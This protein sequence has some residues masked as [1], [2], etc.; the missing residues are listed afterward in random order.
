MIDDE[1]KHTARD[2]HHHGQC[3]PDVSPHGPHPVA[4]VSRMI[5]T[6]TKLSTVLHG[7]TRD[8]DGM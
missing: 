1:Y 3:A 4:Y 7:C 6:I 2:D 5:H 8:D